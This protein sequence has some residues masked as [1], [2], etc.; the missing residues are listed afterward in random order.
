[1]LAESA[2]PFDGFDKLPFDELRVCDTAGR[3]KA[4]S[5]STPLG[6]LSLSNGLVEGL[7]LAATREALVIVGRDRLIPPLKIRGG[8]R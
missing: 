1:L 6:T 5:P 8:V 2:C 7:A 3:L 4:P